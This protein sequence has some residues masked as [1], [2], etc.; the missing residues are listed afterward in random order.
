MINLFRSSKKGQATNYFAVIIFL[1]VFGFLSIVGY[2]FLSNFITQFA[3]SGFYTGAAQTTGQNFLSGILLFDKIIVLVMAVL[4]VG[5]AFT[6]FRLASAP[7][8]FLITLVLG[9]VYGLVSYYFNFLFAQMVSQPIFLTATGL[10]PI[11]I[12]ILT[13]LH[14]V[15]LVMIVIGSIT[16]YG[17]REKGQFLT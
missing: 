13:N 9:A 4:I 6:T 12:I 10:F 5:V 14:W 7:I 1:F 3:A 11:T 16:L 2:V 15:M 17:K 8:F